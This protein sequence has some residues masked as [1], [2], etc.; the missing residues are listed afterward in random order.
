MMLANNLDV[1]IIMLWAESVMWIM[2]EFW[3]CEKSAS[4][5]RR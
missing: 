1:A 5:R 2:N 4:K 3:L